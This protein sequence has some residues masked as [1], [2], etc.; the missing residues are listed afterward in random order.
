MTANAQHVNQ[1]SPVAPPVNPMTIAPLKNVATLMD[2]Y[3]AMKNRRHG[4]S[5]LATFSGFSGYGKTMACDFV[6]HREDCYRVEVSSYWTKKDFCRAVLTELMF[7]APESM[8]ISKMMAKI[9]ERLGQESSAVLIIDEADFL[10]EKKMIE[11]VRDIQRE[12]QA[13]IILVGEERLNEKLKPWDRIFDRALHKVLAQPCDVEDA[14]TLARKSAAPVITLADD[15]IASIVDR[16][17]GRARRIS[18]TLDSV[19]ETA[20]NHGLDL[21][22]PRRIRRPRR[23]R[24]PADEEGLMSIVLEFSNT[25]WQADPSRPGS[26]SGR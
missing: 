9:A 4:S 16:T 10:A 18:N 6:V 25:A 8:T 24:R 19:L 17:K 20:R 23:H 13:S 5:P 2:I 11:L 22:Q 26:S 1:S 15:L 7:E 14:A 12:S 3:Y 21:D